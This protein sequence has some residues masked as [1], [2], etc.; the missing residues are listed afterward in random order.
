M[1]FDNFKNGVLIEERFP[2][3]FRRSL[4]NKLTTINIVRDAA[5]MESPHNPCQL[6]ERWCWCRSPLKFYWWW[7]RTCRQS[8]N[9]SSRWVTRFKRNWLKNRCNG[10]S[11][12]SIKKWRPSQALFQIGNECISQQSEDNDADLLRSNGFL[13]ISLRLVKIWFQ[14]IVVQVGWSHH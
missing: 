10:C 4:V 9:N 2:L 1:V 6:V 14:K 12:H 11:N 8:W 13:G 3:F 7:E 5:K